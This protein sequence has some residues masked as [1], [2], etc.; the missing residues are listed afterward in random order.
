M[1]VNTNKT[2]SFHVLYTES[3]DH[4]AK[5][6]KDSQLVLVYLE[7][8]LKYNISNI[9]RLIFDEKKK[10]KNVFVQRTLY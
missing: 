7:V 5:V 10:K 9:S 1:S 6:S 3:K 2:V 8:H 4:K